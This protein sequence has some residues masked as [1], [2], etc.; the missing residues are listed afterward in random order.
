[1]G[2]NFA[3]AGYA[4]T[5]GNIFLDPA[6]LVE[7]AQAEIHTLAIGYIRT[8]ELFGKSARIDVSVPLSD[9]YWEGR[10][11]GEFASTGRPVLGRPA[12]QPRFEPLGH[13]A[14]YRGRPYPW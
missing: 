3:A 12:H 2:I 9:G 14:S 7:D 6:L 13:A 4:Y 8:F 10:I 1:M 11:D 5:D